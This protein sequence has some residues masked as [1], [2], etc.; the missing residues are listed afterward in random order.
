[1][2]ITDWENELGP[3]NITNKT[4]FKANTILAGEVSGFR[5]P[6]FWGAYNVIEPEKSI[7]QAIDKIQRQ[8]RRD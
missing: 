7:Q 5:D 6:D 8:I 4:K 1:M 3:K 2:L